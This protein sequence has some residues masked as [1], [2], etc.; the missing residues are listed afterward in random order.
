[1]KLTTLDGSSPDLVDSS[2]MFIEQ[3]FQRSLRRLLISFGGI[4]AKRM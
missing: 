3:T 2:D 4:T 1:M